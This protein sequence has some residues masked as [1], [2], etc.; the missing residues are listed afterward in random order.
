MLEIYNCPNELSEFI[1]CGRKIKRSQVDAFASNF[2]KTV[3]DAKV[4][5][6]KKKNAFDQRGHQ[7]FY[8]EL[9]PWNVIFGYSIRITFGKSFFVSSPGIE[10][11]EILAVIHR[12]QKVVV[13]T[14]SP[15]KMRIRPSPK[16]LTKR[17]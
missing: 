11:L 4:D 13:L 8:S 12:R 16:L 14:S 17:K 7:R 3:V 9:V 15:E 6:L 1:E 10:S 2:E 5:I